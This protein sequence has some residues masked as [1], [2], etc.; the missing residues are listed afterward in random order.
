MA[1]N[2]FIDIQKAIAK[3][4]PRQTAPAV[5]P[6]GDRTV[7]Q[8]LAAYRA[9]LSGQYATKTVAMYYGDIRELSVYLDGRR[10]QEVTAG[11]LEQ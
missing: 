2:Q 5:A 8:T 11:D 4:A 7:M 1:Q 10:L 3:R 6:S 9:H